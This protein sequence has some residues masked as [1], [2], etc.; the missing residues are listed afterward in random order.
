M[1]FLK[2]LFP[3]NRNEKKE[4]D[5]LSEAQYAAEIIT[6]G[7]EKGEFFNLSKELEELPSTNIN[8]E[9]FVFERPSVFFPSLIVALCI[10]LS[11][12]FLYFEII[13]IGVLRYSTQYAEYSFIMI[14]GSLCAII[15]NFFVFALALKQIHFYR[16]YDKYES[17]L[18]YHNIV[19][20]DDL[21]E[22]SK[23]KMETVIRDLKKAVA[24]KYIPQGHFGRKNLIFMTSDAVYNVYQEKPAFY[25]KYY[26]DLIEERARMEHRSKEIQKIMDLGQSYIDRIHDTGN[27]IKD[28]KISYKLTQMEKIVAMI[29]H[30]VDVNPA[31]ADKLGLF[32]DYYLP[33]TEKLLTAYVNIDQKQIKGKSLERT[34][35]DIECALDTINKSFEGILEKFYQEQE[36]DIASDISAMEI[37]MKQD[38]FSI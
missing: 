14:L 18:R 34:K 37:I 3:T 13:G 11:I 38:N 5:Y 35:K 2:Q 6:K 32:L 27:I 10:M 21:S 33:T 17:M 22:Y 29:F 16:R 30:E 23:I 31:Q 12:G 9:R 36:M 15:V 28:K 24:Q 8:R 19:L 7:A 20:M 26:G 4:L 1:G 25:D